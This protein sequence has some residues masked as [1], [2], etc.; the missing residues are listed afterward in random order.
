[1][2]VVPSGEWVLSY[3]TMPAYFQKEE[4]Q[5]IKIDARYDLEIFARYIA[6]E[7]GITKRFVGEE[8]LDCVTKQY[9]EQ[10]KE[11]LS[12]FNIEVEEIPRMEVSNEIV[13]ASKARRCIKEKDWD[14]LRLL[15]PGITYKVCKELFMCVGGGMD[16]T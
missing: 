2:S 8:P 14:G 13:S 7:M 15:V 11:I 10:M 16:K 3:K 1:M 4:I 12:L 9:N 5:E 6:P